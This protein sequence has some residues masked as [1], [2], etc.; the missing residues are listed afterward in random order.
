MLGHLLANKQY[1]NL[2]SSGYLIFILINYYFNKI[3]YL[4]II[5]FYI[6][7][8]LHIK[9]DWKKKLLYFYSSP[10][11]NISLYKNEDETDPF[12]RLVLGDL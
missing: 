7:D 10:I 3:S 1:I 4:Y 2:S 9:D 12:I 6:F 11:F 5:F 8:R